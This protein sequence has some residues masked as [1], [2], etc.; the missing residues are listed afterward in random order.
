MKRDM[1]LVHALLA[2]VEEHAA[3]PEVNP[4]T[5]IANADAATTTYHV[6]LC[7]DA[8]YLD[9]RQYGDRARV[10]YGIRGLTWLGHD[11]LD[12]ARQAGDL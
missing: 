12:A 10:T 9:A 5:T 1:A 6:G 2:W 7:V 3:G 4:P 11:V 8:G